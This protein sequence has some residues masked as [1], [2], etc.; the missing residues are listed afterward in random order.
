[1]H[2]LRLHLLLLH[3][4]WWW[5]LL[6]WWWHRGETH[7]LRLQGRRWEGLW[8]RREWL[9]GQLWGQLAA[10]VHCWLLLLL[11]QPRQ[12]L[13]QPWRQGWLGRMQQW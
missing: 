5:Q 6:L 7:L 2:Q 3:V 11:L 4:L 8:G 12:Q 13:L 9:W 1:M 10:L